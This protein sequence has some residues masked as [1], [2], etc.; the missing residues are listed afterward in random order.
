[1]NVI[2]FEY[3]NFFWV[4]EK[5]KKRSHRF[6]TSLFTLSYKKH[7]KKIDDIVVVIVDITLL[8]NIFD[9]L[10]LRI[11]IQNYFLLTLI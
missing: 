10:N 8:I 11:T 2:L 1:M 6:L 7:V 5:Y 9:N 4:D 3:Y